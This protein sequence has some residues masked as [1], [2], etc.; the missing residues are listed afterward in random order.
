MVMV[1]LVSLAAK[2]TVPLGRTP[3]LNAAA[4]AGR[5]AA[6][7]TVYGTVIAV[8]VLPVRVTVKVNDVVAPAPPSSLT[9]SAAAMARSAVAVVLDPAVSCD[10]E[11]SADATAPLK[12][13]CT[14]SPQVTTLPSARRAAKAKPVPVSCTTSM[15]PSN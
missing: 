1:A 15:V 10:T 11:V 3:P 13:P 12:P 6:G 14:W 5:G 7:L 8:P 4:P 2:A 9:A